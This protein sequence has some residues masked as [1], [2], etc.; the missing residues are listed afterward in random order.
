MA[1]VCA[2]CGSQVSATTGSCSC[3]IVSP[4]K[5]TNV[6]KIVLIV[7]GVIFAL[8]VAAVGG[9]GYIG[10]RAMHSN[11]NAIQVGQA[12]DVNEADLGI[13]IYPGAVRLPSGS[14]RVKMF[15]METESAGYT[16]SDPL[17]SVLSFYQDKLNNY[18]GKLETNA[19]STSQSN[20]ATVLS[21]AGIN[22][23]AKE[24]L[25]V[26]LKPSVIAAGQ[27]EITISHVKFAAH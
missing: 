20:G 7:V 26:T 4:P 12:A 3:G 22:G 11:G 23:N 18:Q 17:S 6:W 25:V 24:T 19:V 15:G 14:A 10:W 8:G 27:T 9:L 16:T 1:G 13:S 21:L 2:L 5:K